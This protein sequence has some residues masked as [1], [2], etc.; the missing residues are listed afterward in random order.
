M[1]AGRPRYSVRVGEE[2]GTPC[3]GNSLTQWKMAQKVANLLSWNA[4]RRTYGLMSQ[5]DMTKTSGTLPRLYRRQRNCQMREETRTKCS[6]NN[7]LV[8][9]TEQK[10]HE[11]TF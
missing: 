1:C 2:E 10:I 8:I 3:Y 11:I 6:K 9:G 4:E 7:S 5:G